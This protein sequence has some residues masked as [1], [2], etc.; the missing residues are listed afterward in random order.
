[1]NWLARIAIAVNLAALTGQQDGWTRLRQQANAL[2]AVHSESSAIPPLRIAQVT[3]HFAVVV[4]DFVQR[5]NLHQAFLHARRR[6]CL[7]S[8]QVDVLRFQGGELVFQLRYTRRLR[9]DLSSALAVKVA[10]RLLVVAHGFSSAARMR[11]GSD[12]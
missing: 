3:A 4:V 9:L 5:T 8:Y 1:M 12:M 2:R 10:V 11:P 6:L 7:D